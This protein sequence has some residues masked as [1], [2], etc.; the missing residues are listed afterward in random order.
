MTFEPPPPPVRPRNNVRTILIVVGIVLVLCCGGA[1]VGGIFLFRTVA[2]ATGPAQQAAT[3]YV[4]EV[5]AGDYSTAYASLC[6]KLRAQR[7]EAEF[8]RVQAAQLKISS[9]RVIGTNVTTRN[10]TVT[11]IVTMRLT[12]AETGAEFTQGF[13]LLKENGQWHVCE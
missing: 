4:D 7:T 3:K 2:E 10:T 1:I 9:Y 8:T 5:M 13:P 11:A 12:Q 6:S